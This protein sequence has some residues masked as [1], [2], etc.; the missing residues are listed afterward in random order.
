MLELPADD[1]Q[2]QRVLVPARADIV[3]AVLELLRRATREI[4]CLHH[5]LSLFE[6]S[7][8]TTVDA[9]HALLHAAR[10]A[11]VRLLVDETDWLDAHAARLRL[12]QRQF[13]HAIEMRRACADDPVG[14]DALFIADHRHVLVLS[15]SA[16][17]V[18]EIWLNNQ[19]RAQ[20]LVA[21]FDR[22]WEGGAHN[23]PVVPLGL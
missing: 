5:D 11:H 14:E 21:A 23:L 3:P 2:P 8:T 1:S 22:R 13:S 18:G 17:A 19:P 7:Q 12:L 16:Q 15:R 20:P 10:N 9:M 4:R 6:L